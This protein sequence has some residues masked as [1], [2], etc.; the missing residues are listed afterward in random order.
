MR[1]LT[2]SDFDAAISS[3]SLTIVD[4]YAQWCGPC[5]SM[6]P[7]LAAIDG[8]GADVVKVDIDES[9][10]LAVRY[11]IRSVPTLLAIRDGELV[12]M[13]VGA[14]SLSQLQSWVR[15]HQ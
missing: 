12:D 4:F 9:P 6:E 7:N 3:G 5:K 10:D 14:Q 15:Q 8:Q 2:N 11:G 13:K 1:E